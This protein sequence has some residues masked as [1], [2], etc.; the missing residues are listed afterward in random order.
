MLLFY[1]SI[2]TRL[3][4]NSSETISILE[5]FFPDRL[6]S[7]QQE[8]FKMA[9]EAYLD[10]NTK[11]NLIS[12]KDADNLAVRHFLHSLAIAK[13]VDFQPGTRVLDAG[14]GGGFPGV[15][16]AI[17]YPEVDFHLVDSIGKKIRVVQEI[18]QQLE[19]ENVQCTVQRV[20]QLAD[21]YDFVVSRAVAPLE[22]MS[23][24]VRKRIH[25]QHRN[26]IGN[27]I[28]YLK[29]G[30][31]MTEVDALSQ[32]VSRS[33]VYALSDFFPHDFF[34]TKAL[35]WLSWCKRQPKGGPKTEAQ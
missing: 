18:V 16:L 24:W 23:G 7:R 3:M 28:L 5:R 22:K 19:L 4:P 9:A 21:Q 2:Q 13:V 6:S 27:G 33:A 15:P 30:D 25:C 14:T 17:L 35:V 34:E 1:T 26:A 10:W 11:I 31:I 32:P 12:R 29:G 8:Q 20:E